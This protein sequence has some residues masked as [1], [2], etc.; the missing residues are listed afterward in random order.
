MLNQPMVDVS[1]DGNIVTIRGKNDWSDFEVR[2]DRSIDRVWFTRNG[3]PESQSSLSIDG[4]RA[5]IQ[6]LTEWSIALD[7]DGQ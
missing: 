6:V 5:L 1:S 4:C 3:D 7:R 2:L